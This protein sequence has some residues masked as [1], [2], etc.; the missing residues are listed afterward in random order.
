MRGG[1]R[2]RAVLT[3]LATAVFAEVLRR[4]DVQGPAETLLRRLT[5]R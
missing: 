3:W 2:Y 1:L 5:Y 4:N